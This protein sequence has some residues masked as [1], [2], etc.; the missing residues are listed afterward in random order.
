MTGRSWFIS[1]ADLPWEL[2]QVGLF[3]GEE[4][5]ELKRKIVPPCI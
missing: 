2:A 4:C 5:K 3:W 1:G